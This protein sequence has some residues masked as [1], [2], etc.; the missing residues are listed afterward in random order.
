MKKAV[1]LARKWHFKTPVSA[2]QSD[3][4]A[5][6]ELYLGDENIRNGRKGSHDIVIDGPIMVSVEES[7]LDAKWGLSGIPDRTFSIPSSKD[8]VKKTYI[9]RLMDLVVFSGRINFSYDFIKMCNRTPRLSYC[10]PSTF[11]EDVRIKA[12]SSISEPVDP[13]TLKL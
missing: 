8:G 11:M 4:I 2:K 10:R 7:R 3:V 1:K 13:V 9:K 12:I 5:V 6:A